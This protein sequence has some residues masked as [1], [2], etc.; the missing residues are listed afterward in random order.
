MD[1]EIKHIRDELTEIKAT[2]SR[3]DASIRGNGQLGLNARV[4]M[5]ERDAN[6]VTWA[7]RVI[8]TTIVGSGAAVAR[9]F[10]GGA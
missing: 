2:L 10:T 4:S 6:R 9:Y 5:L 7:L 3:I 1:S 8:F